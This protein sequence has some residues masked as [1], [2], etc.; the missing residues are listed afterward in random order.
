MVVHSDYSAFPDQA[1]RFYAQLKG[2]KELV[3]ADGN[4][5]DYYDS[6]AQI[7]NAAKHI[8]RYFNPHLN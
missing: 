3:W 4:H 6:L 2:E 7:D 8:T 1:K 5:F